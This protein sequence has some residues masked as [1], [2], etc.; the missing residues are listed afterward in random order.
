MHLLFMLP[1]TKGGRTQ[2]CSASSTLVLT[3]TVKNKALSAKPC[4]M[5]AVVAGMARSWDSEIRAAAF[6]QN[7][8]GRVS[9]SNRFQLNKRSE[10]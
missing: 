6:D 2:C 3:H 1:R 7:R 8:G 9:F 4:V 10:A 5:C